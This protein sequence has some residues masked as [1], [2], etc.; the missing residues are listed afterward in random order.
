LQSGLRLRAVESW[1]TGYLHPL[2]T[3]VKINR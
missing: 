1:F 3:I 2:T